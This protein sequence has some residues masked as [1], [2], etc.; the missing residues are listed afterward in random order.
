[1]AESPSHGDGHI[2]R[3]KRGNI[4]GQT[5]WNRRHPRRGGGDNSWGMYPHNEYRL[6]D[7]KYTYSYMIELVEKGSDKNDYLNSRK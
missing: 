2:I 5:I 6:L 1:M 7:K 4:N 3:N